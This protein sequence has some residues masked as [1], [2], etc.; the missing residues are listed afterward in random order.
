MKLKQVIILIAL[1][2]ALAAAA[3]LGRGRLDRAHGY[4]GASVAPLGSVIPS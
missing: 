4:T 2:L 3:P 1:V